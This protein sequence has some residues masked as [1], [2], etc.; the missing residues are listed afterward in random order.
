VRGTRPSVPAPALVTREQRH[1]R[2]ILLGIGALLVFSTSPIFGHHLPTGVESLLAGNDHLWAL[3]LIALHLLL[4]PLHL[5]F[6]GLFAAGFAYA[7]W[8]R[9][10]R[11]SS[12]RSRSGTVNNFV[13]AAI[14]QYRMTRLYSKVT[15][16][17]RH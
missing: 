10:R 11:S 15:I 1:R 14:P 9:T 5:L 12:A 16:A 13:R 17:T 3:C 2:R 4:E 7:V 6:H 8:D